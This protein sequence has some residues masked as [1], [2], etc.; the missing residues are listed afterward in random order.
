MAAAINLPALLSVRALVS[1]YGVGAR[2]QLGQNFLF[3]SNV[4]GASMRQ[5]SDA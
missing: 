2:A 4:T 3:D 5:K 1:L